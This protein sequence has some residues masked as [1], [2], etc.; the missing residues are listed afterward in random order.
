M[1]IVPKIPLVSLISKLFE[2]SCKRKI[3]LEVY[4]IMRHFVSIIGQMRYLKLF[5]FLFIVTACGSKPTPDPEAQIREIVAATLAAL[6]KSTSSPPP[7]PLPS[8][9]P[10]DNR[11]VL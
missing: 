10:V 7:T 11:L 9:T 6:P 5:M 8:S 3:K 4:I 1:D 2:L